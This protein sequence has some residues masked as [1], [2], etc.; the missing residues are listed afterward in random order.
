MTDDTFVTERNSTVPGIRQGNCRYRSGRVRK[1]R[2]REKQ[3][4][5][6]GLD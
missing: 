1:T 6:K 3:S 2:I 4:T 5:E